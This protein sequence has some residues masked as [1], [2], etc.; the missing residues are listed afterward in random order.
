[1]YIRDNVCKKKFHTQQLGNIY[2]P[3][4]KILATPLLITYGTCSFD[5]CVIYERVTHFIYAYVLHFGVIA[6][7]TFKARTYSVAVSITME[8]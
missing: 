8:T 1:M 4:S 3:K 7:S 6:V 2:T 5:V